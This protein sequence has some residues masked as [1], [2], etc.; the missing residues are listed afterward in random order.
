[1]PTPAG[2]LVQEFC[3]VLLRL[4]VVCYMTKMGLIVLL[5]NENMQLLQLQ[6][7]MKTKFMLVQ[8]YNHKFLMDEY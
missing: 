3:K 1:M 7:E 2:S 4:T 6:K 8:N 5:P